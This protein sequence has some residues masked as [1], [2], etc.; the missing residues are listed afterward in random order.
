MATASALSP[1]RTQPPP[2]GWGG[3]LGL[4]GGAALLLLL[5]T[6]VL[7]PA[8]SAATGQ[9]P[10]VFWLLVGGLGVFAPLVG[11]GLLLLKR[12][13]LGG[14][15][16]LWTSRL[17][18]RRMDRADWLWGLGALVVVGALSGAVQVG[19]QGVHPEFS[20]HPPFMAFEPLG[21]GRYWILAAWLPFWVLNILGEE[22]LWRGV[23]LPR[24]EAPLGRRAWVAN[25]A[26][27]SL[28]HLAFGW[29]LMLLLAPILVVLP[30][31][32]QR[33]RNTWVAVLIHGGLNGPAFV[34]V[35]LGL[36]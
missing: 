4:F 8:L 31:V 18:F 34:A 5:G 27:W 29:E 22:F 28:F 13:R 36:V 9:E 3:T 30:Y 23:V 16:G 15:R 10:V 7:I 14:S 11:L 33:R 20:P 21:P 12:E 19:L 25:A 17:R 32:A 24:Q 26:G 1:P 6:H 35:A 2:L